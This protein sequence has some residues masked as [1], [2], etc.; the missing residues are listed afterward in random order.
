ML[1]NS[2]K[3]SSKSL[4]VQRLKFHINNK[5]KSSS[6][7][8]NNNNN[9]FSTLSNPQSETP[10]N[11]ALDILKVL[12]RIPEKFE[13]LKPSLDR[14]AISVAKTEGVENFLNQI[15][16][17]KNQ[18]QEA[19]LSY[20][21]VV[22]DLIK[23]GK[24]TGFRNIR[25]IMLG[26]YD[27][28]IKEIDNRI[29]DCTV[30]NKQPDGMCDLSV[31]GPCLMVL[32]PEKYAVILLDV[33]LN[34][35]LKYENKPIRVINLAI[36][37]GD[38][39]EAEFL[40][41]KGS[42]KAKKGD[43]TIPKWKKQLVMQVMAKNK[44][45]RVLGMKLMKLVDEE[46]WST[47][48]KVKVGSALL[49]ILVESARMD[50]GEAAF[51]HK[52]IYDPT[53]NIKVGHVELNPA[54]YQSIVPQE[55]MAFSPR[56]LPMLI[57]PK[58][59]NNKKGAGCYWF[60]KSN[61]MRTESSVQNVALSQANISDILNSLDY[62]GK[63]PWRIN[64]R[65][66]NIINEAWARQMMI[67]SLPQVKDTRMPTLESCK[68]T[69]PLPSSVPKEEET[70]VE[71]F[72]EK[73]HYKMC[74][75]VT[76]VNSELH[77]LRCNTKLQLG[78]ADKFKG[79]KIYYPY[80]L[81][82]R[83]RAYPLPPNLNHV[84]SDLCRGLLLFD[85]AKPLGKHGMKWLKVHLANL[86][87]C[88]KISHDKRVEFVDDNMAN[89]LDSAKR[90]LDGQ[91][92]WATAEDP[93]QALSTCL[94]IVA[95]SESPVVEEYMCRLP[96]H[97]DGSCNGLQHYAAL[98][99]DEL[100]AAAV[101]LMPSVEP[102]DVYSKVLDIVLE[103][104]AIDSERSLDD[105]QY[106]LETKE[107]LET[108]KSNQ[109]AARLLKNIVNRKVIKQTV[110]TSVYGV[111]FIGARDQIMSKLEGKLVGAATPEAMEADLRLCSR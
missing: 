100:G 55:G 30:H 80:N 31:Y 43:D 87:G 26:W 86:F 103:K 58:N 18:L 73:I 71:K 21:S 22:N 51:S 28:I 83:G 19:K 2:F 81:D 25:E 96:V 68:E 42:M 77:S 66:L 91:M 35:A 48:L 50:T 101:N 105:F 45:R 23:M 111:T 29:H 13:L 61:L 78:I 54:V 9:R 49:G 27:G 38:A 60:L 34:F 12:K 76:K 36:A 110:M 98:G 79:K 32:P 20:A 41:L 97:Q 57:P 63:V 108:H 84:Q 15:E 69:I 52:L 44:S 82:F 104:I 10:L 70:E 40:S 3:F 33:T 88:N 5:I 106:M 6:S 59:W 56:F 107:V 24:G 95:A 75:K 37:L 102:Q 17:E 62:L 74:A 16:L 99:K 94:E 72:Y 67:G 4:G 64:E 90:P 93:F 7:S 11:P 85:E 8:F 1:V 53:R 47:T 92:W 89:V 46:Q 14:E 109:K 39:V 65:V